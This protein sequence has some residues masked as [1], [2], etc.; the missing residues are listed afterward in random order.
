MHARGAVAGLHDLA[1]RLPRRAAAPARGGGARAAP[2]R[3][4]ADP[5]A[6]RG[7]LHDG[8]A[9]R[10]Q[11]VHGVDRRG[12][13]GGGAERGRRP[14]L[15]RVHRAQR[16]HPRRAAPRGAGR[17]VARRP[18][19]ARADRGPPGRRRGRDRDAVRGLL[20]DAARAL[21]LRAGDRRARGPGRDRDLRL[22]ARP[23]HRLDRL[24]SLERAAHGLSRRLDLR[25]RRDGPRVVRARR[26]RARGRRGD[27][28][29]RAGGG[30]PA[31]RGRRARGRHAG[32][33]ARGRQQR[34]PAARA[35]AARRRGPGR[36]PR[37]ASRPCPPRARC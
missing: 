33:G 18:A 4:R 25:A 26:R 2:P 21:L 34:R 16:P 23:R 11:R 12:P 13:H 19:V 8:P 29:R 14:R 15:P 7:S 31:G 6:A 10:R 36:V 32:A 22:A 27:R 28:D 5:A 24:A 1:L 20:H 9:R 35:G 17:P 37:G 30:D 3:L